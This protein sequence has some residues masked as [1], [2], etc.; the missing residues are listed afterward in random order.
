MKS[1]EKYK[2]TYLEESVV[3]YNILISWYQLVIHLSFQLL[4][5][6]YQTVTRH[7]RT[8]Q[9]AGEIRDA[10]EQLSPSS[11]ETQLLMYVLSYNYVVRRASDLITMHRNHLSFKLWV[12][13]LHLAAWLAVASGLRDK[14]SSN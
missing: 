13:H 10:H 1:T 5:D 6:G 9:Q 11:Y 4:G 2:S 12:S 14:I 7:R 3:E 8:G